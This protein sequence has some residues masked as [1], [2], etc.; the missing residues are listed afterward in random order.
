VDPH[1]T[2]ARRRE[3]HKFGV[4]QMSN[5]TLHA[6]GSRS[7]IRQVAAA[8]VLEGALGCLEDLQ[9]RPHRFPAP[10]RARRVESESEQVAT[11]TPLVKKIASGLYRQLPINMEFDDLLQAGMI[12]LLEAIRGFDINRQVAFATYAGIRIHGAMMDEIRRVV[13]A[14]RS[15]FQ[16]ARRVD[17]AVRE[18]Q[19]ETGN[20]AA[21]HA[22]ADRLGIGVDE[23]NE[24]I[25]DAQARAMCPVDEIVESNYPD[26]AG[27][28]LER[29]QAEAFT[30][31]L[32]EAIAT[33]SERE[34]NVMELYYVE[35]MKLHEIGARLGLT[36]SRVCQLHKQVVGRLR[37]ALGDWRDESLAA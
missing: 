10:P 25:E 1:Q 20:R 29:V 8:H 34:R 31:D 15:V 19:N 16:K 7:D 6:S 36:E 37:Q 11:H 18:I 17:Q 13:W 33:L 22:V 28:P 14:P 4:F 21:R 35:D 23:C 26:S 3:K 27:G 9:T 2:L 24:L 12:G 30:D 32:V 5:A